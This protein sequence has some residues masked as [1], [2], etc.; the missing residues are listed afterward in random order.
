[1]YH[2]HR[3]GSGCSR[4][5]D[6][7]A[8]L[9]EDRAY[10]SSQQDR[11]FAGT[12]C[13]IPRRESNG[14]AV[15]TEEPVHGKIEQGVVQWAWELGFLIFKPRGLQYWRHNSNML[16]DTA[17]RGCIHPEEQGNQSAIGTGYFLSTRSPI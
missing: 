4:R 3:R 1:M 12:G 2:A 9:A 14:T 6:R 15:L 16:P 13:R 7:G 17:L 11:D 5:R 8:K 10:W